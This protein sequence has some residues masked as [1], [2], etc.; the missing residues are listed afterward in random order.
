ML[1]FPVFPI[2]LFMIVLP[3]VI[4]GGV[5]AYAGTRGVNVFKKQG[6]A[7]GLTALMIVAAAGIGYG[8][9][10]AFNDPIPGAPQSNPPV[11]ETVPPGYDPAASYIRDGANVLSIHTE[12]VLANR[13]AGLIDRYG[14]VIGVVTCNYGRDDLY[15]YAMDCAEDM[16]LT[17]L[18]FIVVLD[19]RGDNYWLVQG[20]DLAD[21]FTDD[22]CSDY[23]WNYME[24]AFAAGDYDRAVLDLT[25]MLQ[26]WYGV[27]FG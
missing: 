15:N 12:N 8:K 17:G 11:R 18:D 10:I 7:W 19:I 4:A 27:Y 5:L 24:Q 26:L 1:L 22:D 9:A 16:G 23:A 14:V 3:L 21:D 2:R 13:V 6:V 20:A 25:E